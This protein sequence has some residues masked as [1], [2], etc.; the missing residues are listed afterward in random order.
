MGFLVDLSAQPGL[1]PAPGTPRRPRSR[2]RTPCALGLPRPPRGAE[3]AATLAASG[4]GRGQRGVRREARAVSAAVQRANE[5]RVPRPRHLPGAPA[6]AAPRCLA[7][8]AAPGA[9]AA[10]PRP[11][12][13]R[14]SRVPARLTASCSRRPRRRRR[15]GG[16]ANAGTSG[17]SWCRRG[18]P[19]PGS[20][21][22]RWGPP[23]GAAGG[24]PAGWLGR[25]AGRGP[26]RARAAGLCL[27]ACR[28][29]CPLLHPLPGADQTVSAAPEPGC[30]DGGGGRRAAGGAGRGRAEDGVTWA[31][32]AARD[33]P[34]G[35]AGAA[36]AAAA[37]ARRTGFSGGLHGRAPER[38]WGRSPLQARL[39][40]RRLARPG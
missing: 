24:R 10:P 23:V 31:G 27:R 20:G 38:T 25:G 5:P 34:R 14:P 6:P 26:G 30:G 11:A 9:C 17:D 28:Q 16:A 18:R 19:A 36:A 39:A 15:P 2:S 13:A 3:A 40:A 4:L 21:C 35:R 37:V 33:T 12:P 1:R 22:G 32:P 7:P 29:P 8:T